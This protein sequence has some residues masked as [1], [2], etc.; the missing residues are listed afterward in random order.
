MPPRPADSRTAR[1][2][3][4]LFK[5]PVVFVFVSS[6]E[7]HHTAP[8]SQCKHGSRFVTQTHMI[9]IYAHNNNYR[10]CPVAPTGY[11]GL[12][13]CSLQCVWGR[14]LSSSSFVLTQSLFRAFALCSEH[15]FSHCISHISTVV[16]DRHPL[17][18][19]VFRLL[20]LSFNKLIFRLYT[21]SFSKKN[22][23]V[24]AFQCLE[25]GIK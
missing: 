1:S 8:S 22:C 19:L 3:K 23:L 17:V 6:E 20:F 15:T 13:T 24:A 18:C 5:W 2:R 9:N 16:A 21:S 10:L 4:L 11:L 25:S 14:V 7:T 12:L